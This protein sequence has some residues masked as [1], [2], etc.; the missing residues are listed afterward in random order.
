M[1]TDILC[2]HAAA[3]VVAQIC[4]TDP[5]L[6]DSIE[7]VVDD[8]RIILKQKTAK[9]VAAESDQWVATTKIKRL[10]RRKLES[11]RDALGHVS[12]IAAAGLQS[13]LPGSQTKSD[14]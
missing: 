14:D 6:V 11:Y 8:L 1:K 13:V 2:K 7:S 12:S 10:A 5:E 9:G 3:D 4:D